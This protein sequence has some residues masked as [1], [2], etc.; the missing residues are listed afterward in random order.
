M[1]A[2]EEEVSALKEKLRHSDDQ[3]ATVQGAQ[4]SLVKGNDALTHLFEGEDVQGV[5]SHFDDK[6][7]HAR[8]GL[9]AE[10]SSRAD[11]EMYVAFANAQKT[12]L[13]DELDKVKLQL[14][15]VRARLE[16]SALMCKYI[17]GSY[18]CFIVV[19]FRIFVCQL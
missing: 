13:K 15:E 3:L 2:L 19:I 17:F 4:A 6:L 11:L 16:S 8:S 12:L 9:E 18:N 7:R 14:R 1:Y 10:K 5:L